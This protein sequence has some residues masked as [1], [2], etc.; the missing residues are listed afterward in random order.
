MFRTTNQLGSVGNS[1]LKNGSK[2]SDGEIVTQLSDTKLVKIGPPLRAAGLGQIL[3]DTMDWCIATIGMCHNHHGQ[4][5]PCADHSDM[6]GFFKL[7][8]VDPSKIGDRE[9]S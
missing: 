5:N 8:D 9:I 4:K 2:T 7:T 1:C 3:A 6:I